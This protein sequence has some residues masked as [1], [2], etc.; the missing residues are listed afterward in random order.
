MVPHTPRTVTTTLTCGHTATGR[1][2]EYA[3]CPHGCPPLRPEHLTRSRRK[4]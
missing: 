4:G 1:P 3:T 2:G